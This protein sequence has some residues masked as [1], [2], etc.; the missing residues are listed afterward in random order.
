MLWCPY[1]DVTH[2]CSIDMLPL[3]NDDDGDDI[4]RVVN[5]PEI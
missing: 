5:F 4:H 3:D 1:A 2:S